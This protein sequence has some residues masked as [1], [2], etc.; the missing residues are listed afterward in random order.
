[1]SFLKQVSDL[2][3]VLKT[4]LIFKMKNI[5]ITGGTGLVGKK[6]TELLISKGF[7]V[8]HLSRKE[9]KNGVK[10]FLWDVEKYQIDVDCIKNCDTIIHLAGAGVADSRWTVER[11]KEILD[12]RILSSKLLVE[13]LK[14]NPNQVKVFVS[15]SA[16]GIYGS[17]LSSVAVDETASL[18]RDFLADVT[19]HWENSVQEIENLGIR[20]VKIRIGIVLAKEGGAYPK[21]ITPIKYNFGAVLGS[22][23]QFMSWIHIYDL[24]QIFMQSVENQSFNGVINGVAPNPVSNEVFTK[25]AAKVLKKLLFLPNIPSFLLKI[26]LG[27]MATIVLDGKNVKSSKLNALGFDFKYP[28]LEKAIEDLNKK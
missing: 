23:K 11:K 22:G 17:D 16:I 3:V 28:V 26:I 20:L 12:S 24:C 5:L 10:T 14:N 6:L 4:I 18:G 7:S 9:A 15:A 8:S 27:E 13:T 2:L 21:I 1:M 19:Q 25:A